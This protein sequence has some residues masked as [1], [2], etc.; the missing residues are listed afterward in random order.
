[1]KI[2]V[3]VAEI[4]STTTTVNAFDAITT[5]NPVFLGQGVANTTVVEGDVNL[6]L[7]Q[8]IEDLKQNL[9]VKTL[10]VKESFASS[11]AAGGLK[12][13]VHGLVYD[14]TV[15]AAKEA[16]LGA[17]AN[18]HLLT[19]GKLTQS[20]IEQIKSSQLNII[21]IAGGVDYGESETA[22]ENAKT[23]ASLQLHIP[24]VYAGNITNQKRIADVFAS[25]QQSAYLYLTDNVYPRI[26]TLQ[27]DQV[28]LILQNVFEKHIIEAPGME[29]IR[30]SINQTIIPTPAAVLE[31][32]ILLQQAIG[33]L[34]TID[35]G[36]A[37]TD[38]HSVTDESKEIEKILT[39]PEPFAKRTVEGDLGVYIN[40]NI[41][42]DAIGKA[43]L[44]KELQ[45]TETKLDELLD[46][47]M[48]IPL[49]SHIPLVECLTK[50][51]LHRAMSRHA[52]KISYLYGSTGRIKVAEGKD[53]TNTS[54]IIGTG[55]AL[56]HL[57]NRI[58]IIQS[59]LNKYDPIQL[60]PK[61]NTQILID[62]DYIM[63]SLGVLSKKYPS[64]AL[65]L[66]KNSLSL[67]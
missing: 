22:Y 2:D 64:A 44:C 15:R 19:S 48:P 23:I 1:M 12:M 60:K 9:G 50:E 27:V 52:G 40:K 5:P 25:Y 62:N 30:K 65:R 32:S 36:G 29:Q 49:S 16:A 31:A 58:A 66:L 57:P 51:A 20:D 28:R 46:S 67:E 47:Y 4:G 3:L 38:I 10:E 43:N 14:M 54:Y 7:N 34:V 63:A 37:T 56:T 45:I 33:N 21:L 61:A 18:I 8:A 24:I 55:G 17:G 35:I 39:Q 6:G 59:M 41:I 42:I 26:D 53:L 11:S 13:S